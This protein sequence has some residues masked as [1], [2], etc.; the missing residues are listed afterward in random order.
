MTS[1]SDR[2]INLVVSSNKDIKNTSRNE[3]QDAK[4]VQKM[5]RSIAVTQ[6]EAGLSEAKQLLISGIANMA[7]GIASGGISGKAGVDAIKESLT[8]VEVKLNK[9]HKHKK[10]LSDLVENNTGNAN[11]IKRIKKLNNKI[12]GLEKSIGQTNITDA[13][14][15]GN[16]KDF[17]S[18]LENELNKLNFFKKGTVSK[19]EKKEMEN[20]LN[21]IK[22]VDEQRARI[23]K[24]LG[25]ASVDTSTKLQTANTASEIIRSTGSAT[26]S[27]TNSAEKTNQAEYESDAK[28]LE[29]DKSYQ[30]TVLNTSQRAAQDSKKNQDMISDLAANIIENSYKG[31]A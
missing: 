24:E 9:L 1:I 25:G 27:L 6:K 30:E 31:L 17:K 20:I 19:K 4:N 21:K 23:V 7:A 26:E 13:D 18:K 10:E 8:G 22:D 2:L 3:F 5:A 12:N 11:D 29:G 15:F 14:A 28:V 16:L